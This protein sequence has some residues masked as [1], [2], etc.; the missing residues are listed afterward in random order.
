MASTQLKTENTNMINKLL[1]VPGIATLIVSNFD[2]KDTK[3]FKAM[4]F[5]INDTRFRHEIYPNFY[6][7]KTRV[8]K[9]Q[10]ITQIRLLLI[11]V[12]NIPP[13][14][15]GKYESVCKIFDYMVDENNI[16]NLHMLGKKF[17]KTINDKLIE[18]STLK[19]VN[20]EDGVVNVAIRMNDYREKMKEY[21]EWSLMSL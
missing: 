16:D 10:M 12:D 9:N 3:S 4:L 14:M 20:Y 19:L 21:L 18:F 11:I 1:T 7:F 15:V 17:G 13:Y 8:V 2:K 6:D 5:I